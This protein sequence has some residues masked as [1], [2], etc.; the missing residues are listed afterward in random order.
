[1]KHS[2]TTMPS[3]RRTARSA[4]CFAFGKKRSS[5]KRIGT[6]ST[7]AMQNPSRNGKKS[8][9]MCDTSPSALPG[10]SSTR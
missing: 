2:D 1:M 4:G 8:P 9:T 10:S 5:K 6:F 7:N 3:G